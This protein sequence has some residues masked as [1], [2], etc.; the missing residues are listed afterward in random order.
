MKPNVA[1]DLGVSQG[2]PEGGQK[3]VVNNEVKQK[4]VEQN[5]ILA[6]DQEVTQMELVF[7]R[8]LISS[9]RDLPTAR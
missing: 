2:Y 8:N 3:I 6:T 7:I 9:S 1:I 4:I 5:A